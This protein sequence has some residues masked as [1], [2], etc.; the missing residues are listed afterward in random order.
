MPDSD[1][2][3][4]GQTFEDDSSSTLGLSHH[5]AGTIRD[6]L[7]RVVVKLPDPEVGYRPDWVGKSP[8]EICRL[9]EREATDAEGRV[10]YARIMVEVPGGRS[11]HSSSSSG[12]SRRKPSPPPDL[13]SQP[14]GGPEAPAKH[15]PHQVGG[16]VGAVALR[17]LARYEKTVSAGEMLDLVGETLDCDVSWA[18]I[19]FT[20]KGLQNRQRATP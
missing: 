10:D 11:G 14:A 12:R 8:E 3:S 9:L 16:R 15:R 18:L 6:R 5:P 7:G 2:V 4:R 20:L 19:E 1:Y 17:G 13:S